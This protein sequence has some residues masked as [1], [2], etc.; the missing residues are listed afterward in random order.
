MKILWTN[1]EYIDLDE[2]VV[3]SIL[4]VN[5]NR[6]SFDTPSTENYKTIRDLLSS[7]F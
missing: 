3:W 7:G 1:G 5:D 4:W 2:N 6:R